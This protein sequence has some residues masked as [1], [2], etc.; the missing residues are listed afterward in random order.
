MKEEPRQSKQLKNMSQQTGS[1]KVFEGAHTGQAAKDMGQST[2][3]KLI[4]SFKKESKQSKVPP[5]NNAAAPLPSKPHIGQRQQEMKL[6]IPLT[7]NSFCATQ[8]SVVGL[9]R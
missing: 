4:F 1:K 5:P 6:R 8:L 2:S 7:I 3:K 9:K